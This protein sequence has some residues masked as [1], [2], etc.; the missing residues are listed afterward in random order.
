MLRLFCAFT[1]V[2]LASISR[3]EVCADLK[4][5]LTDAIKRV[6]APGG[7][8]HVA[9]P[10]GKVCSVSVGFFDLSRRSAMTAISP[11]K[12][13]SISKTF[14]HVGILKLVE[15]GVLRLDQSLLEIERAFPNL[16]QGY[17]RSYPKSADITIRHL[18]SH[19]SGI[20]DYMQLPE[21]LNKWNQRV[22]PGQVILLASLH[23]DSVLPG[24]ISRYSNTAMMILGRILE[25]VGGVNLDSYLQNSLIAPTGMVNSYVA[26]DVSA[27][28]PVHGYSL[29]SRGRFVDVTQNVSP[30][31][32]WG[33]GAIVSTAS[34][35]ARWFTAVLN[36]RI[37][38]PSMTA[39]LFKPAR[40][41]NG[42]EAEYGLGFHVQRFANGFLLLG[43]G[44]GPLEGNSAT[45]L[46]S[47]QLRTVIIAM[48]NGASANSNAVLGGIGWKRVAEY[49]REKK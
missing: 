48:A 41:S 1:F 25:S 10:D 15:A 4:G 7:Q 13:W 14:T 16:Y 30:S 40:L 37:S 17:M 34:D 47:P 39:Q 22:R 36:S 3:A 6:P 19:T 12:A 9:L 26:S 46:Y 49:L 23:Q 45:M 33:T 21:Y 28:G 32:V 5:E 24:S 11:L 2:I 18:L 42:N 31:M 35:L 20:V 29:A 43:H 27:W 44:G 38:S 8:L